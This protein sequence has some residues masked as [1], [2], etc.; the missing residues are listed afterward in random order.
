[1]QHYLYM[2]FL[3]NLLP[4]IMSSHLPS[5]QRFPEF[6]LTLWISISQYPF[7]SLIRKISSK[8]AQF[9]F[10]SGFIHATAHV[11][12]T[13]DSSPSLLLAATTPSFL[14]LTSV[15]NLI[16]QKYYYVWNVSWKYRSWVHVVFK[17]LMFKDEEASLNRRLLFAWPGQIAP[18]YLNYKNPNPINL[19]T[20]TCNLI[21]K[22]YS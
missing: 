10:P 15:Y 1:M 16:F 2:A 5:P 14:I 12:P 18:F 9:L 21:N 11:H 13:A 4:P 8:P 17:C 7:F 19:T 3:A 6:C 20:T 22:F